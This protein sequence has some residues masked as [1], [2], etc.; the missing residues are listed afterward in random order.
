MTAD[1]RVDF[2]ADLVAQAKR[3]G[4]D[5]ADAILVDAAAIS[6]ARRLGKLEKLERAESQDL[7]LRVFIGKRQAIVASSDRAKTTL[8]ALVERA[9]AMARAA[10]EDPFCG[11]AEPEELATSFPALDLVDP[12]EPAVDALVERARAAE[13]TAL[14]V[15][16]ITNSEGAEASWSKGGVALAASNGFAAAYAR[17]SHSLS[18][19]VLAGEGMAM[20]R[21]YDYSIA[22]HG[23][24]LEPPETLGR[25]AAERTLKR[26]GPRKVSTIKAPVVYDPRVAGGL[27]R[28]LAGAI[29]GAA[30]ARGTSFL[31]SKLGQKI[32]PDNVTIV[33]DPYR[34]RGLASR[35]VDGEGVAPARRAVVDKGVLTTW[36][37][38]LRSA[39]QLK[40]PSTGHAARGTAGPPSP[41]ATNLYLEAGAIRR[42][43]MIKAIDHGLYVTELIGMGVNGVTGDYSRGAAGFWIDKGEIAYPVSE[44]TI[45]GNLNQMFAE[46]SAA[47]DLVFRYGVDA[48]TLRI[49]GMTIA[50]R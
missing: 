45:A 30:I 24:D 1:D 42:D 38:D 33:D 22:I 29:N 34:R 13:D 50:G 20:E 5:A 9:I 25:R 37:L 26:L 40:M 49:D 21:D 8:D 6:H 39:R 14:A 32:F 10:P 46:L 17:T 41:A 2:L 36:L 23:G 44:I 28:H 27:L 48:P 18:V 7:G 19:S 4:A 35:P 15:K 47:D 16:G 3:A 31:K 43:D 12:V 11:L